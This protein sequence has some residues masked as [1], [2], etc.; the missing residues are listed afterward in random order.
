MSW[1]PKLAFPLDKA[2][3]RQRTGKGQAGL[4]TLLPSEQ[5][6]PPRVVH[7][8]ETVETAKPKP[9][10]PPP[11]PLSPL[12]PPYSA[13]FPSMLGD[14]IGTESGDCMITDFEE[15]RAEPRKARCRARSKRNR[16]FPP[17]LTFL[18]ET[19]EMP[20]TFKREYGGDGR[21]TLTAERLRR[22]EYCIEAR[23]E[24]G[25]LAM[26]L[27][28]E[29]GDGDGG[30]SIDDEDFEFNQAFQFE[31][32]DEEERGSGFEEELAK[33]ASFSNLD[34]E[35]GP[36][37]DLRLCVTY[38]YDASGLPFG[39]RNAYLGRPASAPLRPMTPV[40]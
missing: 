17:P 9:S 32:V 11:Q 12:W 10:A 20:W 14:V 13:A 8:C 6:P 40:M 35:G 4:K 16:E 21:L 19:G 28:S 5:K 34:C 29:D 15:V 37:G 38:E 36:P 1:K 7:R 30:Y 39:D 18:R 27:A 25:R 31:R 3:K 2:P 26:R 22:H 33:E 23:R 24:D